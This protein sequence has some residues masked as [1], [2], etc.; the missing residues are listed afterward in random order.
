VIERDPTGIFSNESNSYLR[1]TDRHVRAL[2]K[3]VRLIELCRK[4]GRIVKECTGEVYLS[5]DFHFLLAALDDDLPT[6]LHWVMFV[7]NIISLCD[8]EQKAEWLPL[9]RDWR[10]IGCYAQSEL[11]HG[12][13][14]RALET[15]ATFLPESKGGMKG[16]S[17]I[18]NSPSL[19]R[20]KF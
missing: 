13:N 19:T 11:G 7:P 15:T 8:D 6:S 10:M 16:G 2:A 5:Q 20:V 3:H 1:R 17:F 14:A 9:C 18:I 4:L 12:S